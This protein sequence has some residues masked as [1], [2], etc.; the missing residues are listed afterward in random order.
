MGKAVAES[1]WFSVYKPGQGYWTRLGSAIGGSLIVLWGAHRLFNILEV[2]KSSEYGQFIQVGI[3]IAWLVIWGYLLY[4]M[5][6]KNRTIVDFFISVESEMKK[7]HWPTFRDVM[8]ATKVLIMFVVLL[9]II[10]FM[11]D[12]IFMVFFSTI[13]VLRATGMGEFIKGILGL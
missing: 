10:L 4:W 3:P 5:I 6:G 12:T 13:G 8:G 9:A 7:I 11:V 2:Y 1:K